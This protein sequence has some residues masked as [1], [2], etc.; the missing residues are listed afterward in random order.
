[1]IHNMPPRMT[2]RPANSF[3][4]WLE[5]QMRSR[6]LNQ[7]ELAE[8][9]GTNQST[10]SRWIRGVMPEPQ[11]YEV[12]ADALMV[13]F[14]VVATAAGIKPSESAEPVEG[15]TEA[16]LMAM[17]RKV[18]WDFDPRR[19]VFIERNLEW[20]IKEDEERQS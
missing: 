20:F 4:A 15:S 5:R 1:M 3:G 10:V 16:A 14:D 9:L 12:I 7:R 17:I 11:W 8:K 19:R 18:D 13:D 2:S 6:D